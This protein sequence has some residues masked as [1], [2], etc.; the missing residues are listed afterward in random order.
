MK[1]LAII[2]LFLSILLHNLPEGL[3]IGSS[4]MATENLGMTLAIVIGIHNIP[5]GLAMAL[6]L[7]GS[8]MST[9]KI[10]LLTII[11]GI[12]MGIGSFLGAYFGGVF[13]SLIGVF[14]AIAAGTMMYVV[15]EEI[16]PKTRSMYSIIGF[17]VGMVIVNYI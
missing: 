15:L 2:L 3:A 7:V 10:I 11:A 1:I 17:L 14:L 8:K 13:S 6:S 9:Y 12:P 5:E 16:F 4:F